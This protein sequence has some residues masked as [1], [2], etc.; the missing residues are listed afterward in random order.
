[1]NNSS[2]PCAYYRC[3]CERISCYAFVSCKKNYIL[4]VLAWYNGSNG[5]MVDSKLESVFSTF[6]IQD[7]GKYRLRYG[8]IGDDGNDADVSAMLRW[9]LI[10]GTTEIH[11]VVVASCFRRGVTSKS[12]IQTQK[13]ANIVM[14]IY[15]LVHISFADRALSGSKSVI[16]SRVLFYWS[17]Y[18]NPANKSN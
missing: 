1:M 2:W 17:P 9:I 6:S 7:V 13:W 8:R 12:V 4:V 14:Y 18:R 11:C 15:Y 3:K 10:A 5:G 16:G